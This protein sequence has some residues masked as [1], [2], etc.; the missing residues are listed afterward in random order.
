M[1]QVHLTFVLEPEVEELAVLSAIG[2]LSEWLGEMFEAHDTSQWGVSA[3][4]EVT[5]DSGEGE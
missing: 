3:S 5:E 2:K 4:L 1:I